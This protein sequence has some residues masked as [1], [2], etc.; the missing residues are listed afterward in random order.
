MLVIDASRVTIATISRLMSLPRAVHRYHDAEAVYAAAPARYA[1]R[2]AAELWCE[3]RGVR[4]RAA[5][6]AVRSV[7]VSR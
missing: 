7:V 5:E 3:L 6:S 4:A 1:K 2:G